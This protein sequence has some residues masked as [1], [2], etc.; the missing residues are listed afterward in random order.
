MATTP[1][2]RAEDDS[3]RPP[4]HSADGVASSAP[5]TSRVTSA[6]DLLPA[7]SGTRT[8]ATPLAIA[9]PLKA[10]DGLVSNE[11]QITHGGLCVELVQHSIGALA[12][13][14]GSHTAIRIVKIA[15][16]EERRVGKEGRS[17]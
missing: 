1:S 3:A 12:R 14:E 4:H 6:A 15:R 11:F 5:V 2:R 16:S 7:M 8:M 17:R 9:P 10:G 13:G